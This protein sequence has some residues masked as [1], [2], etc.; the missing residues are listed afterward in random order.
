MRPTSFC[1]G[2]AYV[3]VATATNSISQWGREVKREKLATSQD[4]VAP[5]HPAKSRNLIQLKL[6]P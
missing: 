3:T 2:I 1:L 6:Y 5:T 4:N